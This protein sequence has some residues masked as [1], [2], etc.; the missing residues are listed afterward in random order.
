M[1][2]TIGSL[3]VT[4]LAACTRTTLPASQSP[5]TPAQT[6][7]ETSQFTAAAIV[8]LALDGKL[9]L[10][11]PAR[12]YVPELPDFGTPILMRHFLNQTSGLRSQWPMLTLAGRPP[13]QWTR[14]SSWSADTR[15]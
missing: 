14:S 5:S 13:T 7:A 15:N 11:D 10:D 1:R 4:V 12:K 9:S 6:P 3:L 2:R 8:L